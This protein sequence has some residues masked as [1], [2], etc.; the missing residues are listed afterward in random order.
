MNQKPGLEV[1]DLQVGILRIKKMKNIK[2]IYHIDM[3]YTAFYY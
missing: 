1:P 3:I 2:I